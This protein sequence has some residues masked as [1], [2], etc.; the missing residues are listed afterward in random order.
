MKY[1]L[2][3]EI[4]SDTSLLL[5]KSKMGGGQEIY[6]IIDFTIR[7]DIYKCTNSLV[8]AKLFCRLLRE[9]TL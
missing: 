1:I 4:I 7:P 2:S 6:N 5:T 3:N 9:V 8:N